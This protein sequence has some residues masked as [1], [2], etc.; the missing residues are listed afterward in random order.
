MPDNEAVVVAAEVGEVPL[1]TTMLTYKI[2]LSSVSNQA[3]S[4]SNFSTHI[5]LSSLFAHKTYYIT[6][7]E[8][9]PRSLIFNFASEASK[10]DK[11]QII[12]PRT[13]L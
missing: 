13:I 8:N 9:H 10:V 6:V 11:D 1:P 12:S 7:F 4:D 2:T 5:H 3:F